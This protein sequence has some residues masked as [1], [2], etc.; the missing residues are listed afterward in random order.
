M[1]DEANFLT[2]LDIFG[3]ILYT[4]HMAYRHVKLFEDFIRYLSH[5]QN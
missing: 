5:N 1:I 4:T 3:G 2:F